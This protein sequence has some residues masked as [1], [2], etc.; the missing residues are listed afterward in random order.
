MKLSPSPSPLPWPSSKPELHC[1]GTGLGAVG[2]GAEAVQREPQE[3][4]GGAGGRHSA[5]GHPSGALAEGICSKGTNIALCVTL[6]WGLN[7]ASSLLQPAIE[8]VVH[9]TIVP[10]EKFPLGHTVLKVNEQR[11]LTYQFTRRYLQEQLLMVLAGPMHS[12]AAT[13]T[14]FSAHTDLK[15]T[16]SLTLMRLANVSSHLDPVYRTA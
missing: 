7:E 16:P 4:A 1:S 5:S 13:L 10:R 2:S 11:E 6:A 14:S 9:V 12:P 3:A 15:P 8:P